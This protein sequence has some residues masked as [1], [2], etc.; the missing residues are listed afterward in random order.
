M[1]SPQYQQQTQATQYEQILRAKMDFITVWSQAV[2]R[3]E[4]YRNSQDSEDVLHGSLSGLVINVKDMK[5]HAQHA[6]MDYTSFKES[7]RQLHAAQAKYHK[8][9]ERFG[10]WV[11]AFMKAL[12]GKMAPPDDV[13]DFQDKPLQT[14]HLVAMERTRALYEAGQKEQLA[15]PKV[16][17]YLQQQLQYPLLMREFAYLQQLGLAEAVNFSSIP[18]DVVSAT[19]K[20]F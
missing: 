13:E 18:Y 5:K 9:P 14:K 19:L 3:L 10:E 6:P 1:G 4:D 17:Q 2:Q 7:L 8:N 20:K 12:D 15:N 16:E 11:N